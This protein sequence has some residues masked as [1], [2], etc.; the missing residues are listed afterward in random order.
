MMNL[1]DNFNKQIKT[2]NL[3]VCGIYIARAHPIVNMELSGTFEDGFVVKNFD[4]ITC[5][6]CL[7]ILK[8][9]NINDSEE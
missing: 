5:M 6:T 7:N 8:I 9:I 3:T 1:D 4:A 2:H